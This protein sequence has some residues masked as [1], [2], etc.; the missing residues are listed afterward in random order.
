MDQAAPVSGED[1]A[2]PRILH[3]VTR[4]QRGGSERRVQDIVR[5]LPEARHELLVGAD[6][7]VDLALRQTGADGVETLPHLVRQVSPLDDVRALVTLWR[8][9]RSGRYAAVVTHQSKAGVL[10]RAAA[11]AAGRP[12]V[13]SLS[14]ASFGPGYG[15]LENTL[16][17]RIER[18]L[19]RRTAAFC[20]VG[21]DLAQR[22]AALGVPAGRLH[23]VR[24]GVPLPES[25][26]PRQEA[27]ALLDQRHGT[28][29]GRPLICYVG[30]LEPRKNPLL[31]A[32]LLRRLHDDLADPPDL[33]VLGDGP[34]RQPLLDELRQLGLEEHAVLTGHLTDPGQV[35]DAIRGADAVVLLSEAEGLPQVLVQAAAC[36]TP[37]VAFDVEGV[38]ELV[39]LGAAGV[40]VPLGRLDEV[41]EALAEV[42]AGGA[43]EEPSADLSS[44]SAHAITS[45]YRDV[46]QRVLVT[47][48]G[49]RRG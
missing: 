42:L 13:H 45:G 18:L 23:T 29:P 10:A 35:H 38:R 4:Y 47:A 39:S 14:M 41:A 3:V 27:R 40:A 28:V 34:Q 9:L 31:L 25:L 8:R 15:R 26:R 1:G 43:A 32:R 16:F 30:S 5:A 46:L 22:F 48:G 7:D 17:T 11:A 44:W 36:G 24:S 12:S 37:F 2:A 21:D 20:V 6:S 49:R 33:L 19:G